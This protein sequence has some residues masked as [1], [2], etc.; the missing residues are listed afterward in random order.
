VLAQLLGDSR[1]A[2][3]LSGPRQVGK[4]TILYQVIG[5]LLGNQGWPAENITYFDFSDER[6]SARG[7]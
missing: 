5:D 4:T 1:R 7:L 2:L 3:V 6:L